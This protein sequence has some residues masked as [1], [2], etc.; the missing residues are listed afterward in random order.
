MTDLFKETT[1][2]KFD[3][4]NSIPADDFATSNQTEQQD[5][6]EKLNLTESL[7]K[8]YA[9]TTTEA[10]SE[11]VKTDDATATNKKDV[12]PPT[13]PLP[14]DVDPVSGTKLE[15]IH[16]PNGMPPA[17]KESWKDIP[18]RHQQW[19]MDRER[20]HSKLL[21]DTAEARKLH[22]SVTEFVTPYEP[23]LRAGNVDFLTHTKRLYDASFAL[24]NG[25]Q[26]Q[27]AAIIHNIITQTLGPAGF[28]AL[29]QLASGRQVNIAPFTPP[30]P[31]KTQDQVK[32]ELRQEIAGEDQDRIDQA[33]IDRFNA[34][35]KNEFLDFLRPQMVRILEAGLVDGATPD[36]SLAKAYQ[37]AINSN[38]EV[39]QVLASRQRT[40][41]PAPA[42]K[43]V[44]SV[45]NS[46]GS[47]QR[48][49]GAPTKQMNLRDSII[50]SLPDDMD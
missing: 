18:R 48:S 12:V 40:P 36:E 13:Q 45:K 16:A 29:G 23:M 11:A 34:D 19:A 21:V 32:A 41:A 31:Q 5:Q 28:D 17:L 14:E 46:P 44:G 10:E 38:E 43:P 15:P 7:A 6:P 3:E 20:E 1:G 2:N 27:R 49:G 4:G 24:S 33:A 9:D 30:T 25:S 22:K 35:P 8:A 26:E 37:M 42:Q 39:K 47:G 50:A